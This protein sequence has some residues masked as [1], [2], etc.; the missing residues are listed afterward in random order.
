[1]SQISFAG[2]FLAGSLAIGGVSL[3]SQ[4]NSPAEI[5]SLAP[6][7]EGTA[8]TV[9]EVQSRTALTQEPSGPTMN[10]SFVVQDLV[11]GERI[12]GAVIT[13]LEAPAP[14]DNLLL[15]GD[16]GVTDEDGLFYFE[17]PN[18]AQFGVYPADA[19]FKVSIAAP[20]Y[21]VLEKDYRTMPWDPKCQRCAERCWFFY[22]V[23]MTL[24]GASSSFGGSTPDPPGEASH[25]GWDYKWNMIERELMDCGPY[26]PQGPPDPPAGG[27]PE[28]A[29]CNPVGGCVTYING[30]SGGPIEVSTTLTSTESLGTDFGAELQLGL[31]GF[32][33]AL[34]GKGNKRNTMTKEIG[35]KMT[36]G[37]REFP[38]CSGELCLM[39]KKARFKFEQF[40]RR[41]W[42]D[43]DGRWQFSAWGSLGIFEEKWVVVGACPDFT[44][45]TCE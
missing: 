28:E 2:V 6:A 34:G 44:S 5:Q 26:N 33:F 9:E 4:S 36:I 19:P 42:K 40:A 35:V 8:F 14:Q 38:G 13:V 21:D 7:S 17:T 12:D 1:M 43:E 30:V 18:D 24:T 11:S 16:Y 29:M 22:D 20:G 31:E 39:E 23:R 15:A 37:V 41:K 10:L 27:W 45:L 32:G 3:L 25:H